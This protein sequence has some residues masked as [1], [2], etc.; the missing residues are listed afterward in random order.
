MRNEMAQDLS[1]VVFRRTTLGMVGV[2][3]ERS[4]NEVARIMSKELGWD[5]ARARREVEGL[6]RK[7]ETAL[8]NRI[9]RSMGAVGNCRPNC[10]HAP[11]DRMG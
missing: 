1:D 10:R 9:Q 6:Q 8:T 2:P 11:K 7:R 5:W 3:P 4:L